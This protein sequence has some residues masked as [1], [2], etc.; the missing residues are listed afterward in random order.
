MW[1]ELRRDPEQL[2]GPYWRTYDENGYKSQDFSYS[3]I[4]TGLA[5]T[6]RTVTRQVFQKMKEL[7]G[8]DMFKKVVAAKGNGA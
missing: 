2:V 3:A 6:T 1:T 4:L 8:G 5:M 7:G